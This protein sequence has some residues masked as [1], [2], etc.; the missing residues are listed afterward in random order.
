[1]ANGNRTK[2]SGSNQSCYCVAPSRS[3]THHPPCYLTRSLQC[4]N[5]QPNAWRQKFIKI[6]RK[7]GQSVMGCATLLLLL[8]LLFP[9]HSRKS[10]SRFS[11]GWRATRGRRGREEIFSTNLEERKLQS[12][13]SELSRRSRV[14]CAR[15]NFCL[16]LEC[17][18]W[19]VFPFFPPP[20][21]PVQCSPI[22]L[23][24]RAASWVKLVLVLQRRHKKYKV[25]VV[26]IT[27]ASE[28]EQ[29]KE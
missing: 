25:R 20:P 24:G 9:Q 3:H 7:V 12:I 13:Q 21:S 11:W 2:V 19:V 14:I 17:E 18:L 26:Y 27:K 15:K 22:F 4:E 6:L 10:F 5:G 16:Q 28:K 8:L 29:E 1:M 23:G